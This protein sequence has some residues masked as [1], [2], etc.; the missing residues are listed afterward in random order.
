MSPALPLARRRRDPVAFITEV[1]RDPE[2]GQPFVL[3]PAQERFLRE[4]LTLTADGRLSY[5]ELLFAA[6]KKSGKTALAALVTLYTVVV[7]GGRF[8]EA[9]CCA[10]DLEQSTGRVFQAV[11]RIIEASPLLAKIAKVTGGKIEFRSTGATITA[12]A[13]DYAGAAGSNANL[14]T[15]DELWAFT[16]ERSRRLWDEM[17]PPPT[18]KVTCR[19]VVTYAGFTDESTLL[20]DLHKRGLA[21]DAHEQPTAE[22]IAPDLYRVPGM[23]TYW[24]HTPP[25]PWQTPEWLEEMRRTLR[26]NAFLRMIRNVF[27]STESP[28]LDPAWWAAC[29]QVDPAA[30]PLAAAPGLPVFVGVDASTRRDS[31][32]V[33]AVTWDAEAER[34]RLVAHRIFQPSRVEPLDFDATIGATLRDWR[35]RYAIQGVRYDPWQMVAV[36]QQ[37][38]AEGLPDAG[39][40]ADDGQ[41]DRHR[42]EPLRAGQDHEPDRLRRRA[43]PQAGACRHRRRDA[44]GLAHQ[45][46]KGQHQ[47]RRR[48]GARD[49]RAPVRPG[50]GLRCRAAIRQ[51]GRRPPP[52]GGLARRLRVLAAPPGEVVGSPPV[53]A[54]IGAPSSS[55][56]PARDAAQEER[57]RVLAAELP[58]LGEH[59]TNQHGEGG[60][61]D[62]TSTKRGSNRATL[63]RPPLEARESEL[64]GGRPP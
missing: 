58:A 3:Y 23:L 60:R 45:Q 29:E 59:G 13:S 36:A 22:Q 4:A 41:P 15:F 63:P 17:V 33:V 2:T 27:V 31:T 35:T 62:G 26:P 30:R 39:V 38:A 44:A 48:G 11:A 43:A 42:L 28:F 18:R 57:V 16:S 5:Q 9:Y 53:A 37:L 51:L 8:A 24:T 49:G 50:A 52:A 46:R 54:W 12:L 32:A 21:L 20:E 7:L 1:L 47:D 14:V 19:L 64:K 34:V 25:A 61:A 10:N 55:S 6:P 40:S 56:P